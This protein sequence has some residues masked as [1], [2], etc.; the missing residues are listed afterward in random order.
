M[1]LSLTTWELG[2]VTQDGIK[3]HAT[4]CLSRYVTF[5]LLHTITSHISGLKIKTEYA[6]D[7]W[8]SAQSNW[9]LL[10]G[11]KMNILL[12]VEETLLFCWQ[13]DNG[14]KSP[15]HR[16]CNFNSRWRLFFVH[17]YIIILTKL[18]IDSGKTSKP[19]HF[20]DWPRP[21]KRWLLIS[22]LRWKVDRSN[23]KS[24]LTMSVDQPLFIFQPW[25]FWQLVF[26]SLHRISMDSEIAS[27]PWKRNGFKETNVHLEY[28]Y[29]RCLSEDSPPLASWPADMVSSHHYSLNL[30]LHLH[31]R[32]NR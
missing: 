11:K 24:G 14:N 19:R 30:S 31:K 12:A 23:P 32:D 22:S 27:L 26:L 18:Q 9:L 10:Y 2:W 1:G 20:R 21:D 15:R 3:C 6:P 8:I 25:I 5:P 13:F 4:T 17:S 16:L 29:L 28:T 7:T